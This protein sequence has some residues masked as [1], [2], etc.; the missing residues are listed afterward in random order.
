MIKKIGR[1]W[2]DRIREEELKNLECLVGELNWFSAQMH[3]DVAFDVSEL[4]GAARVAQIEYIHRV[5][6]VVKK[7]LEKTISL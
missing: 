6:K 7:I 4:S 5:D 2:S 1:K 3:P